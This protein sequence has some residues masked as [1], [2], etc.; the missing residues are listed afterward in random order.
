MYLFKLSKYYGIDNEGSESSQSLLK[1]LTI[2]N[3]LILL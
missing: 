2:I 1:Y 3:S